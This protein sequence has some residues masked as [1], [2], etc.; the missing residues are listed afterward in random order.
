MSY[1]GPNWQP[2]PAQA[3]AYG[4]PPSQQ[5][6][7]QPQGGYGRPQNGP[8]PPGQRPPPNGGYP[9]P[10][11]Q[12]HHRPPPA[13]EPQDH[14]DELAMWFKAV[15]RNNSG[16]IDANELQAALVNG[17]WTT[18]DVDTTKFLMTL[19]DPNRRGTIDYQG[20]C[21]VWDYIKQWQGI[22]KRFDQDRSGTIEGRELGAALNQFGYN[23]SPALIQLLERKYGS[24]SA[25][26]RSSGIPFDRFVRC[27]VV[28]KTLSD[29]FR[30]EDRQ[31]Q[32]SAMLSYE[33]FMTIVL[34]C[35]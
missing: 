28:V 5:Y 15:D 17:D 8:P 7:N 33:K 16:S 3:A 9:P 2:S 13:Q 19:F 35:P 12:H 29:S 10:P 21:G 14:N 4:A 34:Q 25:S 32:G 27:C 6:S 26:G 24:L 23:L 22:F 31:G 11:T 30:A 18:F 20:F 1:G